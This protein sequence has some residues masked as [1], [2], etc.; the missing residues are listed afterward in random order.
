MDSLEMWLSERCVRD[1]FSFETSASLF[2][3]W[4]AWLRGKHDLPNPAFTQNALTRR[5]KEKGFQYHKGDKARG[6]R[7]IR[8]TQKGSSGGG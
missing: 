4:A 8:L 6:V 5:L 3:D 2:A 7:G 1:P